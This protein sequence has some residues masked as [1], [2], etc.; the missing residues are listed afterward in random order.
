MA[1][2]QIFVVED[3]KKTV[4]VQPIEILKI[5]ECEVSLPTPN[6]VALFSN[7]SKKQLQQAINIHASLFGKKLNKF[8]SIEILD[9]DI[10][11]LFNYLECIQSSIVAIYTAI[12]AFCN[13]AIPK[14]YSITI[15]N[16]K[17]VTEVWDKTAIERWH[18]TSDK[19]STILPDIFK[20]K[21]P[22]E[23]SFWPDF[24]NLELIRNDIV[25]QKTT[26]KTNENDVDARFLKKLLDPTVFNTVKSGF[27]IIK[28]FCEKDA[29]HAYFP[30]GFGEAQLNPVTLNSWESHFQL[31]RKA[32]G[33][34]I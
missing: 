29:S 8:K 20:S 24:K 16:Q 18:K 32:D 2:P 4:T 15:K 9:D 28:F 30:L 23:M 31:I 1:R 6:N 7:I 12:E 19:I 21:S 17:G 14:N 10:P 3:I 34:D 27:E 11:R 25:H 22:K 26:E 5:G 33:I 13:I